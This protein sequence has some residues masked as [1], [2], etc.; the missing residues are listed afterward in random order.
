[1][2]KG[3]HF[4]L[5]DKHYWVGAESAAEAKSVVSNR[6]QGRGKHRAGRNSRFGRSVFP[7]EER[8][9]HCRPRHL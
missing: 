2:V 7:I 8:N 4:V 1:M 3:W 9:D 5:G 6:D